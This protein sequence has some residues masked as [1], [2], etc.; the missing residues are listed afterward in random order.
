[1][2][3]CA[4]GDI[5]QC[6]RRIAAFVEQRVGA[7]Q[8]QPPRLDLFTV[9]QAWFLD[10]RD[11]GQFE[12]LYPVFSSL[13][14]R[15]N[16]LASALQE[17]RRRPYLDSQASGLFPLHPPRTRRRFLPSWASATCASPSR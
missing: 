2:D 13:F 9:P 5:L 14:N 4:F 10:G 17:R 12:L 11:G 1:M 15:F 6:C 16:P 7:L 8:D 3:A